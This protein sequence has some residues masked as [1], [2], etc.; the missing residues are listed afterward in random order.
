MVK[1][2]V[3]TALAFFVMGIAPFIYY[4]TVYQ[5]ED[6]FEEG[7]ALEQSEKRQKNEPKKDVETT[8]NEQVIENDRQE[9]QN[10]TDASPDPIE[11]EADLTFVGLGDSLTRGVGDATGLGYLGN[12]ENKLEAAYD[13]EVKLDNFGKRGQRSDQLIKA[14][15][16]EEVLDALAKADV[17]FMTIGANDVMQVFK[18]HFFHLEIPLFE[19]QSEQ[20]RDHLREIFLSIREVNRSAPIYMVGIFNPFIQY[21]AD[22]T[23]IEEVIRIWNETSA[24]VVSQIGNSHFVSIH[25][26]FSGSE[27]VLLDDDY[28]HPNTNGYRL[29]A[30]EILLHMSLTGEFNNLID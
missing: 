30:D 8:D 12:I 19:K 13:I 25:T 4:K 18:N 26:I 5:Y 28:F 17:I 16:D 1:K 10:N 21:F 9:I 22:I 20:F 24:D 29:I 23:E 15:E 14:L 27:A 3:L 11:S 6:H 2:V 7:K